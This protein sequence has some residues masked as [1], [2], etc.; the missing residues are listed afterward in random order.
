MANKDFYDRIADA[1]QIISGDSS[2]I[3]D[4]DKNMDYYQRIA[5]ALQIIALTGGHR[6][7]SPEAVEQAIN[8]NNIMFIEPRILYRII[9]SK[10]Q[11]TTQ[12]QGDIW[13][14]IKD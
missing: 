12:Q 13:L 3:D 9:A 8:N 2:H 14:V 11:P 7:V 5:E 4:V 1:L 6:G 10:V